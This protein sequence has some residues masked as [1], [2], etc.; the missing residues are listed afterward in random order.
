MQTAIM[1]DA[2]H[3]IRQLFLI[4]LKQAKYGKWCVCSVGVGV[5]LWLVYGEKILGATLEDVLYQYFC[6]YSG[7]LVYII[8]YIVL[9]ILPLLATLFFL[10]SGICE[11]YYYSRII[12]KSTIVLAQIAVI[13]ILNILIEIVQ[14]FTL[15]GIAIYKR[16]VELDIHMVKT[17]FKLVFELAIPRVELSLLLCLWNKFGGEAATFCISAIVLI[18][19]EVTCRA[20]VSVFYLKSFDISQFNQSVL[21]QDVLL[22]LITVVAII[23]VDK[24]GDVISEGDLEKNG[25]G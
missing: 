11:E 6:G 15:S 12:H 13:V 9:A 18:A 20:Y 7:S 19:I 5:S 14:L 2:R 4:F 16:T 17:M 3:E 8:A 23:L 25:S 1:S 21:L 24:V 22:I 10:K